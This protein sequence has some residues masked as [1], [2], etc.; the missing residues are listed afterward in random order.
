MVST[1][2]K[3]GSLPYSSYSYS[4][5]PVGFLLY[6]SVLYACV[7]VRMRVY[8]QNSYTDYV[9]AQKGYTILKDN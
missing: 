6:V 5:V 3:S 1:G 7:Y 2:L 9:R 8:A 4:D